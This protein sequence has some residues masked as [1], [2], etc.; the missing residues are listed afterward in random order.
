MREWKKKEKNVNYLR[1]EINLHIKRLFKSIDNLFLPKE[2]LN[3]GKSLRSMHVSIS[4]LCIVNEPEFFI[5]LTM[6][7]FDA[8]KNIKLVSAK[9][10]K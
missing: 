6:S 10:M 1:I 5:L 9:E 4:F 8:D 2:N 3:Y 7:I